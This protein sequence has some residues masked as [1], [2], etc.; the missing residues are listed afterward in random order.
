MGILWQW[1]SAKYMGAARDSESC[2]VSGIIN[3]YTGNHPS[4]GTGKVSSKV[5][6]EY[7]P[8]LKRLSFQPVSIT[9]NMVVAFDAETCETMIAT[10]IGGSEYCKLFRTGCYGSCD[11]GLWCQAF[12]R[13]RKVVLHR[14]KASLSR[15]GLDCTSY[16]Q[17]LFISSLQL[18]EGCAYMED[19]LQYTRCSIDRNECL[20]DL[21]AA[22]TS[23]NLYICFSGACWG[24]DLDRLN[25]GTMFHW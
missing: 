11:T 13:Q 23:N 9:E 15:E 18:T 22:E 21:S 5:F 25:F 4:R 12:S 20:P 14:V 17:H 19:P 7:K 24:N 16:D 6:L 2:S 10:F 1:K 3:Y 8:R